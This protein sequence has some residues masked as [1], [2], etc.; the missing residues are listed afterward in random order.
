MPRHRLCGAL[1]SG[2][3]G[4]AGFPHHISQAQVIPSGAK[5]GWVLHPGEKISL[6]IDAWGDLY[7]SY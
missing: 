6:W 5:I 2:L 3:L 1:A 7:P 4:C